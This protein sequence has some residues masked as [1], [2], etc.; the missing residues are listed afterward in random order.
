IRTV[1]VGPRSG[2]L[3][4]IDEGVKPGE[5]V[6]VE[7]IQKVRA[8]MKVQAVKAAARKSGEGAKPDAASTPGGERVK[9]DA[10]PPPGES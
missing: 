2:S 4:V 9:P 8:G 7:G 3:W 6:I 5:Q 1:Q 10:A